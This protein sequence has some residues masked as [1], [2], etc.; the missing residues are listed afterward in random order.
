MTGPEP[1]GRLDAAQSL[2]SPRLSTSDE[3]GGPRRLDDTR[4][5]PVPVA[6]CALANSR[7]NVPT[8]VGD[9]SPEQLVDELKRRTRWRATEKDGPAFMVARFRG[10][11][12]RRLDA[13][14]SATALVLDCDQGDP[15][16]S[17]RARLDSLGL[18]FLAWPSYNHLRAKGGE[19]ARD[20]ARVVVFLTESVPVDRYA[21]WFE[22]AADFVAGPGNW[23]RGAKDAAR[24][25]Y[26]PAHP[27]GARGGI[28]AEIGEGRRP[29]DPW[30]DVPP[31]FPEPKVDRRPDPEGLPKP[32]EAYGA[33]HGLE[34]VVGI[35]EG[36]GYHGRRHDSR[37]GGVRLT[38]PGK[39]AS[40]GASV[41]VWPGDGRG[42]IVKVFSS[43]CHPLEADAAYS[44][45]DLL[46]VFEC[47]GDVKKATELAK[48]W[49]DA[50]GIAYAKDE[51]GTTESRVTE[52][53]EERRSRAAAFLDA[54]AMSL[55]ELYALPEESRAFL[56]EGLLPL[57]SLSLLAAKPKTG[58][59][60]LARCLCD[61][62][63]SGREFL[64]RAVR[65]G[66]VV[67]FA[68][69]ERAG[70]VAEHF[71]R[72][73]VPEDAALTVLCHPAGNLGLELIEEGI[74]RF[75]PVLVVIDPILKLIRVADSS[76]YAEVT[77]K[78]EGLLTLARKS[79][80]C[81]LAVHH[82]RKGSSAEQDPDS[83]L[84][85]T[86]LAGGVDNVL[87]MGRDRGERFIESV[88][89]YGTELARTRL[90]LG[91][92]GRSSLGFEVAIEKRS[93]A[94][95]EVLAF[96]ESSPGCTADD[97]KE[98]TEMRAELRSSVLKALMDEGRIRR[99]GKG[100]KG[101]PYRYF[102]ATPEDCVP[103]SQHISREQGTQS[104]EPE[105]GETGAERKP[106][107]EETG[108]SILGGIVI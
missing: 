47:G 66:P 78:L 77:A 96:I 49:L 51:R 105:T 18:P 59:S 71:A 76:D 10:D 72:M 14:E 34:D 106:F 95:A 65:R 102:V 79:G 25:H 20:R 87:I 83:V 26:L 99:T 32:W 54:H 85:S 2:A 44:A 17:V 82:S 108:N 56:V 11:P 57:E 31:A 101:D 39:R 30:R 94:Q 7:D 29:L 23:D 27:P 43:N 62:V 41:S 40:E 16:A 90:I 37:T 75:K 12:R 1:K 86:G 45:F 70:E 46:K 84:G 52:S 48:A 93:T 58:K 53:P 97:L 100:G 74:E 73:G 88:Q 4:T 92:D 89:R 69:E 28:L 19:P 98:R 8:P 5:E 42:A 38:R 61:A 63:A 35:L 68:L 103:C 15:F 50:R 9:L 81:I 80:V 64:G 55:R 22:R 33:A 36:A 21:D 3:I 107:I 6:F 60:T 67:Y 91:E 13:I 104:F 24:L